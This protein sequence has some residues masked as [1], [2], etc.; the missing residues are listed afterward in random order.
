MRQALRCCPQSI[1]QPRLK[2]KVVEVLVVKVVL[3]LGD[4]IQRIPDKSTS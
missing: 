2:L 1:S 4:M 3:L